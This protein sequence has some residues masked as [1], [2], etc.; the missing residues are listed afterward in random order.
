MA[1]AAEAFSDAA[2]EMKTIPTENQFMAEIVPGS[3]GMV[4]HEQMLT[5]RG[6]V[7]WDSKLS[8]PKTRILK[9]AEIQVEDPDS[10]DDGESYMSEKRQLSTRYLVDGDE[11]YIHAL[12]KRQEE[13]KRTHETIT[14]T[15]STS[16]NLAPPS[17]SQDNLPPPTRPT[18]HS[19]LSTITGN[20][21][22]SSRFCRSILPESEE[23][24]LP[25]V[26]ALSQSFNKVVCYMHCPP[27]SLTLYQ[28]LIK[29]V[30]AKVV[31]SATGTSPA[32]LSSIFANFEREEEAILLLP[33]AIYTNIDLGSSDS[34]CIVHVGWP[35]NAEQY[36]AQIS[37]HDAPYSAVVACAGDQETYPSCQQVLFHTLPW[38]SED[39]VSFKQLVTALRPRFD[40]ALAEIPL[41]LKDTLYAEWIKSHGPHGRR[42]VNSWTPTQLV[43]RANKFILEVLQYRIQNIKTASKQSIQV[44]LPYVSLS[45]AIQNGLMSAVADGVLNVIENDT[46]LN[47][48]SSLPK[49]V[50]L[51]VALPEN[52]PVLTSAPPALAGVVTPIGPM[53]SGGTT[54]LPT[55]PAEGLSGLAR[56]QIETPTPPANQPSP[57]QR[58]LVGDEFDILPTVANIILRYEKVIHSATGVDVIVATSLLSSDLLNA[59]AT[60]NGKHKAV[61]L[62]LED[63]PPNLNLPEIQ[64]PC[65]IHVGWPA[66]FYHCSQIVSQTS[67]CPRNNVM[68]PEQLAKMRGI[69]GALLAKENAKS[70]EQLYMDWIERHGP[71]GRRFVRRWTSI[72]LARRANEYLRKTLRYQNGANSATLPPLWA[73]FVSHHRLQSAAQAGVLNVITPGPISPTPATSASISV[74]T[75]VLPPAPDRVPDLSNIDKSKG[76]HMNVPSTVEIKPQ[77]FS[78][79][80]K[81]EDT[82]D[83]DLIRRQYLV[84]DSEFDLIP[85]LC[86]LT[87][88]AEHKNTICYIKEV[89]V[90]QALAPL[91]KATTGK[92]VFSVSS[93]SAD[94]ILSA[95]KACESA[96]GCIVLHNSFFH[97]SEHLRNKP[98]SQTIHIGWTENIVRWRYGNTFTSDKEQTR[99]LNLTRSSLFFTRSE[100]SAI[101]QSEI[102]RIKAAGLQAG[103]D[104]DSLLS[105]TCE[106]WKTQLKLAPLKMMNRC[107]MDWIMYYFDGPRKI[108]AWSAVDV[109]THANDFARNVLLRGVQN[110]VPRPLVGGP[111]SVTSGFAKHLK[112]QPAVEAGILRVDL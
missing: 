103:S 56:S 4:P 12:L 61:L 28:K 53:T 49:T 7:T 6:E 35:H 76:P 98:F 38:P 109:V 20:Y 45:F 93:Q 39:Y 81:S 23:D 26:C 86:Y 1:I 84:F 91:I 30:S 111:P 68:H 2:L 37:M 67:L 64:T 82:S 83:Q 105:E 97:L 65:L 43:D 40:Q 52:P 100:F 106:K 46:G 50:E 9:D 85:A 5:S 107:Y 95:A 77:V 19:T 29:A 90:M 13:E 36:T 88:A 31:Y 41:A 32:G 73:G 94:V 33:E 11:D 42:H 66:D 101:P 47:H 72:E 89:F 70:K 60:F 78:T 18:T 58:L 48:P 34:L 96:A 79:I 27:F 112:L 63:V 69:F 14:N 74:S 75:S 16:P 10:L 8:M 51:E 17:S 44:L 15:S 71:H 25:V 62:L 110:S 3:G 57:H 102:N 54:V 24:V 55:A 22:T 108:K 87:K 92:P 59:V 21:Q 80:E 99:T 104:L